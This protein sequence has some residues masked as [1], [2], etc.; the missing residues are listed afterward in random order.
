[1]RTPGRRR[2]PGRQRHALRGGGQRIVRGGGQELA[3][4]GSG[5]RRGAGCRGLCRRLAV[6]GRRAGPERRIG[7]GR[8]GTWRS[9]PGE[10]ADDRFGQPV[11]SR[12]EGTDLGEQ[13]VGGRPLT[14]VLGQAA[15][16]QRPHFG[17]HLI[18]AGGAVDHAVQQ[19]HCRPAAERA[20]TR[21]REGEDGP[22]VEYVARR[23]DVKTHGL[24]G[25][26]ETRRADHQARLRQ[27][28]GFH[29]PGDAEIDDPRAVLRQHHVGRLK[30]PVH[31]ARGVDRGQAFRQACGQRQQRPGRQRPVV[32]HRLS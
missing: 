17:R 26:H 20:H 27:R 32:I 4:P 13:A 15:L 11:R 1:M 10:R 6:P 5:R 31:H 28:R 23:P 30:V 9:A 12:L 14:G 21:G 25:G 19:R 29:G 7:R 8:R 16:D 3:F 22:Q 18:K 24:L 2:T